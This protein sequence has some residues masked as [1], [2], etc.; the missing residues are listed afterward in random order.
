MNKKTK[1]RLA[2]VRRAIGNRPVPLALMQEHFE[3]FRATGALPEDQA[4][5][6]AVW[7]RVMNGFET[8]YL[9][10]G[11]VDVGRTIRDSMTGALRQPDQ[12]MDALLDE[13]VHATGIVRCAARLALKLLSYAGFDVTDTLFAGMQ[14]TLPEY[15]SVGSQLVGYPSVLFRRPFIRQG[16]RLIARID[17]L[18]ERLPHDDPAWFRQLGAAADCFQIHGD[19]PGEPLM[20]EALLALVEIGALTRHS[21]GWD[22]KAEMVVLAE[23]AQAKGEAREA[24]LAKLQVIARESQD[25]CAEG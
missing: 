23:I 4:L 6:V 15:G 3:H 19:L 17:N 1:N 25:A 2:E 20:L 8:H 24:A 18:R 21:A 13:A 11:R 16:R 22:V 14:C 5:A 12:M 9:E 10:G 7:Q